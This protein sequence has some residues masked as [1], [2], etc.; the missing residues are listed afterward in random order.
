MWYCGF[1]E[2]EVE[3]SIRCLMS[4]TDSGCHLLDVT[5]C[6]SLVNI[7][8]SERN[9]LNL[10]HSSCAGWILMETP[11]RPVDKTHINIRIQTY[12]Y[13]YIYGWWWSNKY[14]QRSRHQGNPRF[15]ATF[16]DESL[17]GNIAKIARSCHRRTW[18]KRVFVKF[19]RCFGSGPI[20][21]LTVDRCI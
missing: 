2:A 10:D 14:P 12:V 13:I 1:G 17:N 6:M 19:H 21:N 4:R 5:Y 20:W 7:T 3:L 11:V 8:E 9:L 15:Y 16:L 18:L